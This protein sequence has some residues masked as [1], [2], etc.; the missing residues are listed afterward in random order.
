MRPIFTALLLVVALTGISAQEEKTRA[1][2]IAGTWELVVRGPA[3]HGDLSATMELAQEA[4]K[5]TGTF[6][7]HGRSH[8]LGG[9]FE[10]GEL[11]LETTDT[12]ADHSM[13]FTAKL[14][15][16]GTLAGYLSSSMGDMQWT[17]SRRPK[18]QIADSRSQNPNI[19][20]V[21]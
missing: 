10:N 20:T 18:A 13:S 19:K 8:N 11:S 6:T 3:A 21:H 9:S 1:D 16:D 14:K 12:P 7:A 4:N 15:E 17:A 2:R 5:V